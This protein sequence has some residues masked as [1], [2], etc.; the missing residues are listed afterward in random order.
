MDKFLIN[1]VSILILLGDSSSFLINSN[2]QSLLMINKQIILKR[3]ESLSN[4]TQMTSDF[5]CDLKTAAL[6]ISIISS[7]IVHGL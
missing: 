5:F 2:Q 3:K 1:F 6:N 4:G 7:N